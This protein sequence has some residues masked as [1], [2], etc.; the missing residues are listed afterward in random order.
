MDPA[1]DNSKR[2]TQSRQLGSKKS[3][4]GCTHCKRRRV[5]CDEQ[6][7][8]SNCTRR[9]EQCSLAT[10]SP[11]SEAEA[12]TAFNEG[13]VDWMQDLSLMNHFTAK[14]CLT[15]FAGRQD[16]LELWKTYIPQTATSHPSL[17]HAIL[18]LAALHQAYLHPTPRERNHYLAI[19]DKHHTI[20]IA[21]FRSRLANFHP[22]ASEHL[23][24]MSTI[25]SVCAMAGLPIRCTSADPPVQMTMENVAEIFLL[26]RGVR[27]VIGIARDW[28]I[29]GP[30]S[31]M[32]YGHSRPDDVEVTLSDEVETRFT[33]LRDLVHDECSTDDASQI[34]LE[35]LT[36]LRD[37]FANIQYFGPKTQFGSGVYM[38]FM[39][40]IPTDF[41][42]LLQNHHVAALVILYYYASVTC[43]AVY[44][45]FAGDWPKHACAAARDALPANFH[46]VLDWPDEQVRSEW[47]ALRAGRDRF[48][49][50]GSRRRA[51]SHRP[52]GFQPDGSGGYVTSPHPSSWGPTPT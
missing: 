37:I 22:D 21:A 1:T 34:C 43:A 12:A 32:F 36:K 10:F 18:T 11:A 50:E 6:A 51:E 40:S 31:I 14:T 39:T 19:Y 3:R 41:T 13:S 35:T 47:P 28:V 26:T 23:F 42:R 49:R 29:Q 52:E 5:K 17:M 8:C 45:W 30:L 9:G 33:I 48:S 7:P 2:T 25:I 20:A 44:T 38:S 4:R 16:I 46:G 27:E 24:A 15:I